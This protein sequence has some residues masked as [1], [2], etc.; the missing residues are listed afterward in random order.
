MSPSRRIKMHDS[1]LRVRVALIRLLVYY[2]L[3]ETRHSEVNHN[4]R[5]PRDDSD[6]ED[7]GLF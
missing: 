2:T 7:N 6:V 4:Q 3:R 1:K 5:R